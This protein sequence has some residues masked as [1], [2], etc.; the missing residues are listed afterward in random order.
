MYLVC[1]YC[2]ERNIANKYTFTLPAYHSDYSGNSG[3]AA[4]GEKL[5]SLGERRRKGTWEENEKEKGKKTKDQMVNKFLNC[6]S[7]TSLKVG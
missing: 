7:L 6:L 4:R 3:F 2:N 1:L 5:E